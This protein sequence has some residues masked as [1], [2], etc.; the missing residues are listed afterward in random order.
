MALT[1]AAAPFFSISANAG[2]VNADWK[3]AGDGLAIL[4]VTNNMKWLDLTQ[5]V[6]MTTDFVSAQFGI[7]GAFQGWRYATIAE[8]DAMLSSAGVTHL[9]QWNADNVPAVEHLF[10]IW[11]ELGIQSI[12][13]TRS[14]YFAVEPPSTYYRAGALSIGNAS[15]QPGMGWAGASDVVDVNHNRADSI[16][17]SALVRTIPEP[18]TFAIFATGLASLPFMAWRR[19][20]RRVRHPR[21]AGGASSFYETIAVPEPG[22]F[23]L[24]AVG[25]VVVALRAGISRRQATGQ[26]RK[27]DI[28]Y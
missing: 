10:Q 14:S 25:A 12:R 5:T 24:L 23:I 2:V 22:S 9:D 7:G 6:N 20:Q 19:L 17:G 26:R 4:D 16:S 28:R 3:V 11:G 27:T 15:W 1:L 18:S 13:G 21:P 8:T